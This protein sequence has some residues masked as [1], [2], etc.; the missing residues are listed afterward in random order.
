MGKHNTKATSRQKNDHLFRLKHLRKKTIIE[1]DFTPAKTLNF[2]S[3]QTTM[4]IYSIIPTFNPDR[5]FYSQCF[6]TPY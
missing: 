3:K 4:S 2:D 1:V 5:R 6:F